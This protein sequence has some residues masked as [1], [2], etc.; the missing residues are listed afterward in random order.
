MEEREVHELKFFTSFQDMGVKY[1][2]ALLV[3]KR[4][5]GKSYG[6]MYLC[7]TATHIR[8]WVAMCGT[9][10]AMDDVADTFGSRASIFRPDAKGFLALKRLIAWQQ[11][12]VRWYKCFAKKA[13][14]PELRP[15]IRRRDFHQRVHCVQDHRVAVF[16]WPPRRP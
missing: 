11:R 3:G 7:S 4:H 2:T 9:D 16:Q 10:E 6:L 14:P 12:K 8:R 5:S 1:P 13:Y 15:D